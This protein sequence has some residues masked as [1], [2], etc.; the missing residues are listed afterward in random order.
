MFLHSFLHRFLQSRKVFWS[1]VAGL[2]CLAVLLQIVPIH[3]AQAA[4]NA[5][6]QSNWVYWKVEMAFP[7]ELFNPPHPIQAIWTVQAGKWDNG[8]PIILAEKRLDISQEC[9]PNGAIQ[10]ERGKAVFDG[11]SAFIACKI[12]SFREAVE[13]MILQNPVLREIELEVPRPVVEIPVAEG[14]MSTWVGGVVGTEK[15]MAGEFANPVIYQQDQNLQSD[16]RFYLPTDGAGVATSQFY[17]SNVLVDPLSWQT[18]SIANYFW[19]GND[20]F[21][22]AMDFAGWGDFLIE[23]LVDANGVAMN[24]TALLHL[25]GPAVPTTQPQYSGTFTMSTDAQTVYIG[26]DPEHKTFYKGWMSKVGFDPGMP[27]KK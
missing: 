23:K 12:P 15:G 16:M 11:Q 22:P 8:E 14:G 13:E 26:H 3:T 7:D 19:S 6:Y 25:A 9:Q 20:I 18:N 4:S 10:F 1:L 24:S 5:V 2:I 27:G 17:L 21:L